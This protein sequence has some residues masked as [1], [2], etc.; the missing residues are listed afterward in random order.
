MLRIAQA[1]WFIGV[2]GPGFPLFRWWENLKA[3]FSDEQTTY[4]E[5][6]NLEYMK[7]GSLQ[8]FIFPEIQ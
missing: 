7:R 5:P 3:V 8:C 6:L 1:K 2:Q 4:Q